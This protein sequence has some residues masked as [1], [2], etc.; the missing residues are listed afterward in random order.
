MRAYQL[1]YDDYYRDQNLEEERRQFLR[2]PSL[3]DVSGYTTVD[4]PDNLLKLQKRA[5]Q[6][7]YFTSA[8]P[9]AQK[10]EVDIPITL[11]RG[12][13]VYLDTDGYD[14]KQL[15]VDPSTGSLQPTSLKLFAGGSTGMCTGADSPTAP[16]VLD[17]NGT[18]KVDAEAESGTITDLRR[19][20]KLQEWLEKQALAGSRYIETIMSHF[21]IRGRDA[22]LQRPQFLG[23]G[24]IPVVISEV[25]QH[26]ATSR[27]EV[28][29]VTETTSALGDLA[30]HAVATGKTASFKYTADEHGYIIGIL[31]VMPETGYMQGIP[32]HFFKFDKFDYFWP[33]F[34][35]IGEQEV[36]NKELFFAWNSNMEHGNTNENDSVFGY[37]SRYSEYKYIPNTVHG[38][39]RGNLDTW[40]MARKFDTRPNL[41]NTFIKPGDDTL[42][43]PFAVQEDANEHLWIELYHN[44]RAKRPMPYFGTP[45]L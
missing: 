34:A 45:R 8:L 29:G 21:G 11:K 19:A 20:F 31:S 4:D 22:R 6:K 24:K 17:P 15:I 43:R 37:Q 9:W 1:I 12:A 33:E 16:S 27:V 3:S 42:N 10:G 25:V 35:H 40:H 18:L 30:G 23:G 36:K 2:A 44:I 28:D 26:S 5:W 7:D 41:N 13:E 39:F 38:D 14:D 32:R